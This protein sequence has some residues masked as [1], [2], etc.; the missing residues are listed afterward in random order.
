MY[1]KD[2]DGAGSVNKGIR[3]A[4]GGGVFKQDGHDGG[5][6]EGAGREFLSWGRNLQ[7][8]ERREDGKMKR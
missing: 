1:G 6:L 2:G 8:L 3:F 4:P 5:R 7:F